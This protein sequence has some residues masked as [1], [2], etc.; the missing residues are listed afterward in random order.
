[1]NEVQKRVYETICPAKVKYKEYGKTTIPLDVLSLIALS[2]KE[3]YF[4][5]I[6]IW[7]DDKNPDPIAVGSK[8]EGS[9]NHVFYP[10]ARWGHELMPF[11]MLR[12][13]A[14]QRYKH[15]TILSLKNK[16]HECKNKLENIDVA[17]E[18]YFNA[19]NNSYDVYP[20]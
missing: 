13:E 20:F 9:W 15:S 8:K 1:M 6:Q 17:V 4:D 10:I 16:M 14:L 5:E 11:E 18:M 19:E 12:N 3:G 2:E 7:Y